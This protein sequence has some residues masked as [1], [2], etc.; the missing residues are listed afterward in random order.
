MR[1]QHGLSIADQSR[2]SPNLQNLVLEYG[3]W[4]RIPP[5]A[6]QAFHAAMTEWQAK[7]RYGEFHVS[8]RPQ[9]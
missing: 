4:D 6:W 2:E 8:R 5:A 7:I 1:H 9:T 3:T